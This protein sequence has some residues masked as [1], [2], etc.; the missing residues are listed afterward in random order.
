MINLQSRI[1]PR[2]ILDWIEQVFTVLWGSVYLSSTC[3]WFDWSFSLRALHTRIISSTW[4][5]FSPTYWSPGRTERNP[6][7]THFSNKCA[8][9]HS[10]VQSVRP[11]RAGC[12]PDAL[13]WWLQLQ[14]AAWR[15]GNRPSRPA[16][17]PPHWSEQTLCWGSWAPSSDSPPTTCPQG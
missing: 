10:W 4:L 11:W 5:A 2:D 6:P 3:I 7:P 16:W 17:C 14:I 9:H 1:Q 15:A 8:S 13:P 12:H